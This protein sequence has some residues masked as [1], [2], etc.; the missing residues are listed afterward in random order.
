MPAESNAYDAHLKR[1]LALL[2]L[3]CFR[4]T[5]PESRM[6]AGPRAGA[7]TAERS[8][9]DECHDRA[10]SIMVLCFYIHLESELELHYVLIN[11]F[12][13]LLLCGSPPRNLRTV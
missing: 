1:T 12:V 13:H 3:S 6:R 11:Y 7:P 5:A 10:H 2:L 9:G 4:V 8:C